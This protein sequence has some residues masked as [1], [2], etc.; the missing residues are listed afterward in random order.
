MKKKIVRHSKSKQ[1]K[2][3]LAKK[4]LKKSYIWQFVVAA[5]ALVTVGYLVFKN[6][7]QKAD[8]NMIAP[9]AFEP[10]P[11]GLSDLQL[12]VSCGDN[13]FKSAVITCADKSSVTENTA[14]SCRTAELWYKEASVKCSN[15]C[16]AT[17]TPVASEISRPPATPSLSPAPSGCTYQNVQCVKAP[18]NPVLVCAVQTSLAPSPVASAVPSPVPSS[19]PSIPPSPRPSLLK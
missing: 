11:C 4:S 8:I 3:I 2:K 12:S 7:V 9:P 13:M 15:K 5:V 16:I 6:T 17:A 14:T 18:C 19:I 1:V 10:A